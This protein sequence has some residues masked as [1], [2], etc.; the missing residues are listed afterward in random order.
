MLF[1]HNILLKINNKYICTSNNPK[2]T[3]NKQNNRYLL[4]SI[5]TM[6]KIGI[7][8]DLKIYF[9]ELSG[10]PILLDE[11]KDYC[12]DLNLLAKE[13]VS[14][15]F[16]N[17]GKEHAIVVM[18]KIF[19][20]AHKNVKIF[21]GNFKG[22]ISDN[23]LYIETLTKYLD[24][25][26]NL[27]VIFEDTPNPNSKALSKLKEDK[28]SKQIHIGIA[29]SQSISEYKNFLKNPSKMVHFCIGDNSDK[30]YS[31]YRC[32]TDTEKFKAVLN[33]DDTNFCKKLN[34]FFDGTLSKNL[35]IIK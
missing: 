22:D 4:D 11:L 19:E 9:P 32:E 24:E 30:D 31:I 18:S 16:N 1:I 6:I 33:F 2:F 8:M 25:G 23:P 21:A 3:T 17:S 10:N 26:K 7:N 29:D 12:K 34:S 35:K 20:T 13:K 15:Q 14:I 28:Y 5:D 27:N